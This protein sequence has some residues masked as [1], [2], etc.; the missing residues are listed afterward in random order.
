MNSIKRLFG[1]EKLKKKLHQA[2][3][4]AIRGEGRVVFIPGRSGIGKTALVNW[5]R[6][7]VEAENGIYVS[8]KFDQFQQNIPYSA[9]RSSL[10]SL[11]QNMQQSHSKQS[12]DIDKRLKAAV[13]DLGV[14]LRELIPETRGIFPQ[15]PEKED[16]GINV[17][18]TRHRFI[19]AIKR[20]LQVVCMPEH[21]V[22]IFVDDWQWADSASLE[23]LRSFEKEAPDL[24]FLFIVS[25]RDEEVDSSHPLHGVVSVFK[26]HPGGAESIRVT[27]LDRQ[28]TK[29]MV[30]FAFGGIIDDSERFVGQIWD[31]TRG[32]PFHVKSLLVYLYEA[33]HIWYA[34]E[35]NRW[36]WKIDAALPT[37]IVDLFLR[38]L[39]RCRPETQTLI[40]LA[41]CVGNVFDINTLSLISHNP[42]NKCIDLLR[43]LLTGGLVC[44]LEPGT[45]LAAAGPHYQFM[46]DRVQ[47]AAYLLIP[48]E[49]VS[50]IHLN[51]GRLLIQN[52]EPAEAQGRLFEILEHMNAA[53][54]LIRETGEIRSLADLNMDAAEKARA[55]T[56]FHSMLKFNRSA[57]YFFNK[58]PDGMAGLWKTDYQAALKLSR[59]LAE[60]EFLEGSQAEAE[61]I[62]QD[63][64]AF[65]RTAIERAESLNI[66][67]VHFTLQARYAEA[68][69]K[70]RSALL[71][72][73]ISLPNE[74]FSFHSNKEIEQVQAQLSENPVE[75][76]TRLSMMTDPKMLT[77]TKL[78]ITL[79]PPCYRMHQPLWS[80]IVPKVVNYTISY[81]LV[82]Q[83]GYS[84]PA[85]G[86][87]MGWV[88][89]DYQTARA[90]GDA[91]E[92]IMLEKFDSSSDQSVFYLMVGSS[93][94]H[95]FSPLKY[96]SQDYARANEIGQ[97]S[98]NLQYAAYAFGHNMYCRFFQGIPLDE[99]IEDTTQSLEFSKTRLNH[100]AIDLL[101]GGL[102]VFGALSRRRRGGQAGL[103]DSAYLAQVERN[104]NIQVQC[105][106]KIFKSFSLLVC[107]DWTQ[108]RIASD[109]A[110]E[111]IYTVGTQGLLPWPEH[112]FIRF[113]ILA[114]N[115]GQGSG[116]QSVDLSSEMRDILSWLKSWATLSPENY[117]HKYLLA[118]AEIA[119]IENRPEDAILNY[120]RAI[121][122]ARKNGFTQWGLWLQ[123]GPLCFG[124]PGAM[125]DMPRYTGNWPMKGIASGVP[126]QKQGCWRRALPRWQAKFPCP[127]PG[128]LNL[129]QGT[130]AGSGKRPGCIFNSRTRRRC[131]NRQPAL[132]TR[133][134]D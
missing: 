34:G 106:Y 74:D 131:Q 50:R 30:E 86:G 1:R 60:S 72:L 126:R 90:F 80:V 115:H 103:N 128:L 114:E 24:P 27:E 110:E 45:C 54:E 26:R 123:S 20:F 38:E 57:R 75:D 88:K 73:G 97:K 56:A 62:I 11:W 107:N 17:L 84:Y 98:G 65:T 118:R 117:S 130:L 2:F 43:S 108:A 95:W 48:K 87:L 58:M 44:P 13:G 22:V 127:K 40:S 111:L 35:N 105:I 83:I 96:A 15:A 19:T 10:E 21:P 49:E 9:I 53:G 124:K 55:A 64:L 67:I 42:K 69:E 120:E 28:A 12:Y 77:V 4:Q 61:Q 46:H 70:G 121:D 36:E 116:L 41:A 18:E 113:L 134:K 71:E 79:G 122:S 37:G 3:L 51:I 52:L 33:G 14:L 82:P 31:T 104:K 101:E 81:G 92:Q 63:S 25:Y 125:A 59:N 78:L 85:F 5:L 93:V 68:I 109:E 100:W 91:A 76:L 119:R 7:P 112:K 99:M 32:N 132:R 8:G 29:E 6:K 39:N 16:A 129:P 47:Q 89:K 23:L 133:S 102:K 94:R 66:I